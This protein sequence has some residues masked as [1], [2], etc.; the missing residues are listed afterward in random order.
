MT[1]RL[2]DLGKVDELLECRAIFWQKNQRLDPRPFAGER[3][4]DFTIGVAITPSRHQVV[5]R[6][7][8]LVIHGPAVRP[9]V[10]RAKIS[11]TQRADDESVQ[12]RR[13]GKV[14]S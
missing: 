14:E 13:T 10:G 2:K 12:R 11:R 3:H 9:D 1:E 4:D 8:F 5:V 6:R 7:V